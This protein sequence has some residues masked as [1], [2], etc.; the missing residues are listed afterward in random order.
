MRHRHKP[1]ASGFTL[2]EVL[3]ALAILGIG[4]ALTL[5]LIT[6]SLGNIRKVQQRTRNM[7]YAQTV[8]ELTL[9]DESIRRPTTLRGDFPDGTLWSAEVADYEVPRD[10]PLNPRQLPSPVKLL[11]YSVEIRSPQSPTPDFR[12][13][14]LKLISVQERRLGPAVAR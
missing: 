11:L 13:E 2:L 3:V 4:V 5:S 9:L 7:H 8:M 1:E 10:Q 14:T 6:G 12:L